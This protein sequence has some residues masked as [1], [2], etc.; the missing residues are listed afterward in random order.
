MSPE[1]RQAIISV[2]RVQNESITGIEDAV[3]EVL[4]SLT[5]IKTRASNQSGE[6]RALGLQIA[7]LKTEIALAR[8]SQE[9][10]FARLERQLSRWTPVPPPR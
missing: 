10:S 7:E 3:T 2:A 8:E 6:M 4:D 9:H 1:A 5:E